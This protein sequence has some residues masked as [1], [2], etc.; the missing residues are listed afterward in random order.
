M[1][2][3]FSWKQDIK[4]VD[5]GSTIKYN[6]MRA[7]AAG[8]VWGFFMLVTDPTKN[9]L[10]AL[11]T[12]ILFP[13]IY[14]CLVTVVVGVLSLYARSPFPFAEL[15]A[16][17]TM[18]FWAFVVAVGDPLIYLLHKRKPEIVPVRQPRFFDFH[19]I[20]FVLRNQFQPK[21][22]S[23][24]PIVPP[25]Q[26]AEVTAPPNQPT[27]P[28]PQPIP[29]SSGNQ[30]PVSMPVPGGSF[31]TSKP[32]IMLVVVAAVLCG[33][34]AS[35]KSVSGNTALSFDF[36]LD[37][38]GL[39]SSKAPEVKVDGQSFTS[40]SKIKLGR[41]ELAVELQNAEPYRRNFWVVYGKKDLG[42]L[43]L[44]TSKGSLVVTVNPSPAL[45]VVK[46]D[47]ETVRQGEAPMD[48]EK[49]P[50]GNY[51]LVVKRGDY[52]EAHT[53]D[54]RR[55]QTTNEIIELNLGKV[56]LSSIPA[57]AAYEM[58]GNG[59]HWRGKLPA[60]LEDVPTG[61]Y[62][63]VV[64][65]GDY[66]ETH[67]VDIRRQQTTNEIIELN[68]GK[69]EL[70]SI[71]AD[72]VYEMS[73]N[74]HRWQGKLPAR[75]EDVPT[76][77]YTLVVKHGDY[78][79]THTLGIQRQQTTNEIVELNIGKVELSSIPAD[80]DYE[81]SANGHHWRGKLPARLEDVPAGD[82]SLSVTRRNWKLA[83][84]VSAIRGGVT[85]NITKFPYG[86][87]SVTSTPT[88]LVV[89]TNA[90][91]IG[92]TPI[93]LGELKP[94]AYNLTISD[95][96]NDLMATVNVGAMENAEHAFIFH[97]GMVQLMSEPAGA[98]VIRKGKEIGKT[99]LILNHIPV[100]Q[101]MLELQLQDYVSTNIPIQTLED[102]TNLLTAKLVSKQY[103]QAMSQA[104]AAFGAAQLEQAH[105]FLVTALAI[106]TN[107][108]A[109]M[110]L[111][112]EV[113]KAVAKA[114]EASRAEQANAK[115]RTLASLKWL[116]FQQV[117]SDC[118][119]TKQVQ[120]PVE[121]VNTTYETY[122]DSNGKYK[123][124]EVKGAPYTVM[125]TRTESTFNPT[126]FTANYAGRT[127]GFNCPGNWS[128]SKVGNDGGIMLKQTR[129]L[130]GSD[131]I[132]V[133]A[134]ANNPDALKSLKK[135]QKVTIKGVLTKFEPGVLVQTLH[136][137]NAEL[138]DK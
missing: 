2:E 60:R 37:D 39:P 81:M 79:E 136:L 38:K 78:E 27:N 87:I 104:R 84:D 5:W 59:R 36:T 117:I 91:E 61:N 24:T 73:G 131:N 121:M 76:G 125:Q 123:Q 58:S 67:T 4:I 138:L 43:Q 31:F 129:G 44:E 68:L 108:S 42:K 13:V 119:D 88:G 47:G 99:P 53:V 100:G 137:E 55:Q 70:S 22:G 69:V 74:G 63:L 83:S 40:G 102:V 115:A 89:S 32:F 92:K 16:A 62:T 90:V 57:D 15:I 132:S 14:L 94:A 66:E 21:S 134:P 12:P 49:L 122:R 106:E 112:D 101:T 107:D 82:Y 50:V 118:T 103:L 20:V 64:K 6:L 45:V 7:V 105:K 35:F 9:A 56:E 80:A 120:Y 18:L 65:R 109:A 54:I 113:S 126:K 72:A 71:P 1:S 133:T 23:R 135:G 111:Q 30:V 11:F 127:F 95:G 29:P 3:K 19:L 85:T 34:V 17:L 25:N 86:S 128:V 75:L 124:R 10:P 97:Y 114:E 130:F 8:V 51:T 96:E 48:V 33:S 28:P 52:E 116:D 77:N 98:T 41:H 93:I 110:E 26:I 46:R